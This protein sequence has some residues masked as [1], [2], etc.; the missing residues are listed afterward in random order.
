MSVK[1]LAEIHQKPKNLN[2]HSGGACLK[3]CSKGSGRRC[4]CLADVS[5]LDITGGLL[6]LNESKS[7]GSKAFVG[8]CVFSIDDGAAG[9]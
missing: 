1:I 5:P 8:L 9:L 4:V 7:N 3:F 6:D 2:I